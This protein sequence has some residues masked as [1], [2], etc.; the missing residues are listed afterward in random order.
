[1]LVLV[2]VV[3]LSSLRAMPVCRLGTRIEIVFAHVTRLLSMDD[4]LERRRRS[5][6]TCWDALVSG[7]CST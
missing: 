4:R 2:E 7:W 3:P 1:M 6:L 5:D